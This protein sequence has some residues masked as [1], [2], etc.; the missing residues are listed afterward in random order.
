MRGG[1]RK[2][3]REYK[4]WLGG[5]GKGQRRVGG[6][7]EEKKQ[8]S[9]ITFCNFLRHKLPPSPL[10]MSFPLSFTHSV[11]F[12]LTYSYIN[13]HPQPYTHAHAYM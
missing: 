4:E 13:I 9:D 12:F 3:S 2:R 11:F 1:K 10:P 5:N 8:Q 6:L 7:W